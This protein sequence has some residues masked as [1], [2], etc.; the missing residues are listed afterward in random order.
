MEEEPV[1]VLALLA[2][3][4]S[5]K[6]D[7]VEDEDQPGNHTIRNHSEPPLELHQTEKQKLQP[8]FQDSLKIIVASIKKNIDK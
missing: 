4:E 8:I 7:R 2:L 5:L 6:V 3:R 1:F